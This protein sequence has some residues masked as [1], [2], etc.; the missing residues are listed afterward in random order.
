MNDAKNTFIKK[1]IFIVK[2]DYALRNSFS[3]FPINRIYII[4]ILTIFFSILNFSAFSQCN[5]PGFTD[6]TPVITTD[7]NTTCILYDR[8]GKPIDNSNNCFQVCEGSIATYSTPLVSGNTYTWNVVGGTFLCNNTD[9]N[10]ISVSW[11]TQSSGLVQVT[12]TNSN[13]CSVITS[14][15][16]II[17]PGPNAYFTTIPAG[18]SQT[19]VPLELCDSQLVWFF[20]N[21]KQN[22]VNSPIISWVWDFGDGS[23]VSLVQN[24]QHY[25]TAGNYIA[26]LTVTNECGCTDVEYLPINVLSDLALEISCPTPVCEGGSDTYTINVSCAQYNWTVS[27]PGAGII[28]NNQGP[29]Y[30]QSI[31]I[32]WIDGSMG[33]GIV[34]FSGVGCN[35]TC[36]ISASAVIPI[37]SPNSNIM[38]PTTVCDGTN[39]TF[40]LP[41]SPGNIYTWSVNGN[42]NSTAIVSGQG[43]NSIEVSFDGMCTPPCSATISCNYTNEFLQCPPGNATLTVDIK[44]PYTVNGT[45]SACPGQDFSYNALPITANLYWELLDNNY[46]FVSGSDQTG[47]SSYTLTSTF[48][49]NLAAGQYYVHIYDLNGNFCESEKWIAVVVNQPPPAPGVPLGDDFVCANSSHIYTA[50]PSNPNYYI[51]WEISGCTSPVSGTGAEAT[52]NTVNITWGNPLYSLEIRQVDITSGCKSPLTPFTV[53]QLPNISPTITPTSSQCINTT[54]QYSISNFSSLNAEQVTWEI[55]PA[56]AGSIIPVLSNLSQ[57]NI[58]WNNIITSVSI[59]IH[60]TVCGLSTPYTVATFN[61]NGT[62]PV[63]IIASVGGLPVTNSCENVVVDFNVF[64]A[65]SGTSWLWDF[66]DGTT[67]T[68]SAPVSHSFMLANNSTGTGTFPLTVSFIDASGCPTV[69][70]SNFD[71]M[72]APVITALVSPPLICPPTY[73]SSTITIVTQQTGSYTYNWVNNQYLSPNGSTATATASGYYNVTVTNNSLPQ[74]PITLTAHVKGCGSIGQPCTINPLINPNFIYHISNCA[75]VDFTDMSNITGGATTIVGW[76]WDFGDGSSANTQNPLHTYANAGTYSVILIVYDSNGECN[77]VTIDINVPVVARL[78]TTLS[79]PPSAGADYIL[80]LI[81]LSTSYPPTAPITS[82]TWSIDNNGSNPATASGATSS[83]AV[84]SGH[85]TLLLTVMSTGGTCSVNGVVDVPPSPNASFTFSSGPY[86][87][88]QTE[89]TFTGTATPGTYTWDFG[90][91]SGSSIY[92]IT[93]KVYDFNNNIPWNVT[94]TVTDNYGCSFTSPTQSLTINENIIDGT[95]TPTS[96]TF[97]PGLSDSFGFSLVGGATITAYQWSIAEPG[98]PTL[99]TNATFAVNATG[100]YNVT[101]TDNKG[102]KFTPDLPGDAAEIN[103]PEP[104]IFGDNTLCEGDELNLTGDL[105]ISGISYSWST[106]IPSPVISFPTGNP[107]IVNIISSAGAIPSGT[108]SVTLTI[109]QGVCTRSTTQNIIFSSLPPNPDLVSNINP[110][111][112][113]QA[114]TITANGAVSPYTLTWSNGMIANPSITT[115]TAGY[116]MATLTDPSTGC[117]T[118]DGITVNPGPDLSWAMTGCFEYCPDDQITIPGNNLV[119]YANWKWYVNYPNAVAAG[120]GVVQ[121]LDLSSLYGGTVPPGVYIIQLW[122]ENAN[123]CSTLSDELYITVGQ[124]PCT[125]IGFDDHSVCIG[126]DINGNILIY[127]DFTFY[128]NTPVNISNGIAIL[129][130]NNPIPSVWTVT[131]NTNS[132]Q[133]TGMYIIPPD[134]DREFCF[135]LHYTDPDHPENSC[136]YPFCVDLPQCSLVQ[137][138]FPSPRPEVV[139]N[140]TDINGNRVYT[141]NFNVNFGTIQWVALAS[142]NDGTLTGFPNLIQGP[143]SFSATFTDT[144]PASGQCCIHLNLFD[145]LTGQNCFLRSCFGLPTCGIASKTAGQQVEQRNIVEGSNN[146]SLTLMPNPAGDNVTSIFNY[147][148][149]K[150]ILILKDDK[151]AILQKISLSISYGTAIIDLSNIKSGIYTVELIAGDGQRIIKKLAVIK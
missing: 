125:I 135:L 51:E 129:T 93:S 14:H 33:P 74:C 1:M 7:L 41:N 18:D 53:S 118:E 147:N 63:N 114:I 87:E 91:G 39:A 26:T 22:S 31:N 92:P 124:C 55:V 48:T 86:C 149:D 75:D 29:P 88:D 131:L 25:Y 2:Q 84:T 111:C 72:P 126:T 62:P 90:D 96:L 94:L 42:S 151:G 85:H 21:V 5:Q 73:T 24:P 77:H 64:P 100:Q 137:C 12:E 99:G 38:G 123:G 54:T 27:P 95:I 139:C 82:W 116:Y 16:I 37:I 140:G 56:N 23:P 70:S 43:T 105:G 40:S 127:F 76:F 150:G 81:D 134:V 80:N 36:P 10:S 133:L 128:L 34:S 11:G 83:V 141:F 136:T 13:G 69:G 67:S 71:I 138:D 61:L 120:V 58:Q 17:I 32:Q 6:P 101:I 144:P 106:T 119:S 49:Q 28:N 97:C 20:G 15:C 132:I 98:S 52:G 145:P 60:V 35:T 108:Y 122:V 110:P 102:C 117:K 121:P 103:V 89:I 107:A 66:G 113:G 46:S 47:G 57:V 19:G 148:S 143:T 50:S 115:Y 3:C 68:S 104:Y 8:E 78:T 112:E 146:L 9:C 59:I 79:C 142:T 4:L 45:Q 30:G 109:T 65:V 130:G 44:L